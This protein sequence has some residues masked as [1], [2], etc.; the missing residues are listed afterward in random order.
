MVHFETYGC[1]LGRCGWHGIRRVVWSS[2]D[3][4]GLVSIF[5][6]DFFLIFFFA[7]SFVLFP[8]E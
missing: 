4:V 6:L 8:V 1:G 2:A 3:S 5:V 7:I